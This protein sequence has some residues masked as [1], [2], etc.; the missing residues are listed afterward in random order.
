MKKAP[1]ISEFLKNSFE[2]HL[3][4][5]VRSSLLVLT[6]ITTANAQWSTQSP[7]PT[8]LSISGIGAVSSNRVFISTD[9]N[10]F[11][12]I[13]SLF[14]STDAGNSWIAREIPISLSSPFYG[15]FFLDDQY[16]WLFGNEIY[17]TTDSGTT[18]VQ[19]PS[20][21]STY[22]MEFYT[23]NLGIASGNFGVYLS[24][25]G[26]LLW[27]PSPHGIFSFDFI[28]DQI[29]LGVSDS[30]IYKT[31]DGGNTFSLV[32]SGLA[33]AVNYLSN[34]VVVA[35]VDGMFLRSTDSGT[36]WTEITSTQERNN[37]VKVSA[38]VVLA[39]GRSGNF[40]DYDDRV[41]RSTD[42]GQSW[43][44]LGE[45]LNAS[46]YYGS[47]AFTVTSEQNIVATDGSG[48]MYHSMD[49]GLN[50]L[51]TFSTP[52][53]ILPYYLGSA[54]PVF[55]DVQTGYFGYGPGFII[56]T[57]D[58]GTS[59]FQISSGT[60]NTLIDIA[61]FPNGD[62]IA[63]G[64]SGTLL[65][66]QT[67]SS[68]WS[69]QSGVSQS[70]LK[71]VQVLNPTDVVIVDDLAI[72]YKSSDSGLNWIAASNAPTELSSVED[73]HFNNLQDGWL[74]G[75][76]FGNGA[77]FHTTD[78]GT[79]WNPIP[80]LLGGYIS[81]DVEGSNLWAANVT[82]LY[83][84][85]TDNGNTWIEGN[86]P[87]FP[88]Q[89]QD[90]DFFDANIG[91]AVGWGGQAFRSSD[92]GVTW[93]VLPTPNTNDQL[94]DLFLVGPNEI[95][96]ST[97]SNTAYYSS[98][99]GQGWAVLNIGSSGFGSFSGITANS[100]GDAW[101]VGF[102]GFIEHFA[103]T[104]P[105]PLNQ[106]PV[107]SFNYTT[108]A[109]TVNFTD[110]ST[111]LDG[112]IISWSWDFG[113][114]TFSTEQNPAHTYDTANT[115]IVRLTVTDDDSAADATIR[116]ITVQ[117]YPG[118]TFGD[119]TEVTPLDSLFVTPQDE[120]FWVITTA[121]AD[122]DNDGDLDIAVLGYYVIY[123]LSVE[124]RLVILRNNGSADSVRWDFTY[125]D[126]P[127]SS[128]TSGSSDLAW[129][130]FD[131][132]TDL[133]LTVGTDGQTVLY[134]N[135]SGILMLTDTEL[136][137]YWEDN[138]QA[139]FDLHSI[140]WADYDNDG[141]VDILIPSVFDDSTFSYNTALMRNDGPNTGG[142][143]IFTET[144]SV[145][146]PTSH[147]Q[148]SWADYDGD[149]D[150]DLLLI[151]VAPLTDDG[152]IR[153]YRNDGNG[154]FTSQDI[155][156]TLS[157]EHGEAQWG[158]YDGDGD[159]DILVAG[160]V[161]EIDSTYTHMALRVYRNDNENFV[162]M[163]VISCIPCEGWFDLTAATWADYDSDGDMDILLAGTHN[164]GTGNIE[165][166]ARIYTNNNGIFIESGNELPAPRAAGDRGGT[167]SWFDLDG[168]ADLDYFIAGQYFVPGGNGL[169]EA[170]MHVYRN[171]APGQ[172][173]APLSPTD[174]NATV[175]PD[176][177]VL[178]SW[179][180]SSDDH[181]PGP[182]ITYDLVVIRKGS[183]TPTNPV[184]FL[185]NSILTRLPEP[186][187]IS[188]VNEWLLTGLQDGQYE[189]RVSAVDA[190]YVGSII[191]TG[192]F[193]I[194]T[195]TAVDPGDNLPDDYSMT[196]N[197]PNPFNPAT[198]IKY[199]IPKEGLVTLKVYNVIGEEVATLVNDIKQVG[200][201]N[202]T[203]N[204]ENLSSGV[205]LYRLKAGSFVETKKM[206]LM[207]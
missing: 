43:N 62:M 1:T 75:Y 26:G 54:V 122:Y 161:K 56:K 5:F 76:G 65:T 22:F 182:A 16:G 190:A 165:G 82:G 46:T 102:Q 135:D 89:I 198:T 148:S 53:S 134:R 192:T 13:G 61:G 8:N 155:L 11:D 138:D 100:S 172:N 137:G 178:L 96:V 70:H 30:G 31:T 152:F 12:N 87:D 84:R 60:G 45:I 147:A 80:D 51:Q 204:A 58:G 73:I 194:G 166:R 125:I 200:N 50:W 168:D 139:D 188:A 129:G 110:T 202:L 32:Q 99:G 7:V 37:L 57:T 48:N 101:V 150:L 29:G 185:G 52:G 111:D 33:K 158:D 176:S 34:S 105:P 127:F 164:P 74:I 118:G 191:A 2:L 142:G 186:G 59:W 66:N 149:Q 193:N 47:F 162:S 181:T 113:D 3:R 114:S 133:D 126:L 109:L 184:E 159:L 154:I 121:P 64:E 4:L 10:S 93:Q 88:F 131:N 120:D 68:I 146:S 23:P 40:P 38:D 140:T 170:Q 15:L 107:A 207:K 90:M 18:W 174:L 112:S 201:Y 199:S 116:I 49:A 163:D 157:V 156:G 42:G 95:W 9:D 144:D 44:D 206:I 25:D 103:G 195:P 81:L 180:A 97:N 153:R 141:D 77:L 196:Q 28:D 27:E 20:L 36:I 189:W 175:Q 83:Y 183:H 94:T 35:V 124:D 72:V 167:F 136:P 106:P 115:Y 14:E 203:F 19:L 151:N 17:S 41:F 79:N 91:Y 6:F 104:P 24:K 71:A 92:G 67:G 197:Y 108:N 55:A 39:W 145:F 128:L 132:D 187:N 179:T 171:D 123:N 173:E 119:F 205:Y 86:L 69:L 143:W 177:T 169:V 63:V 117:P 130:D 160:N 98:N 21:G 85:S 78:G